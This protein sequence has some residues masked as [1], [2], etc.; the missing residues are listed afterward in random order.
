MNK[1]QTDVASQHPTRFRSFIPLPIHDLKATRV[2]LQRWKDHPITAGIVLGPNVGGIYPGDAS[3]LPVW[4]EIAADNWEEQIEKQRA[5]LLRKRDMAIATEYGGGL[6]LHLPR[7]KFHDEDAE[8]RYSFTD[9]TGRG[10]CITIGVWTEDCGPTGSK[11]RRMPLQFGMNAEEARDLI[12][13]LHGGDFAAVA[14]VMLRYRPVSHGR[15]ML[16][17][18][19]AL[20][21]A[22]KRTRYWLRAIARVRY[23]RKERV[24][25]RRQLE[26]YESFLSKVR[27]FA[28]A[29]GIQLQT[30]AGEVRAAA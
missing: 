6:S 4:E 8:W 5:R 14:F 30:S 29:R 3:L 7:K 23:W 13:R 17:N 22:I 19:A 26:R 20:M 28:Q 15:A 11:K 12:R 21:A 1:F 25:A 27:V 16:V 18:E 2:E 9:E 10:R 24:E